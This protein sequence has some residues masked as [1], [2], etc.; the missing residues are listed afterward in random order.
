M[1]FESQSITIEQKGVLISLMHSK[2]MRASLAD[3]LAEVGTSIRVIKVE[4]VLKMLSDVIRFVL[5][6]IVHEEFEEYRLVWLVLDS[7]QHIYY[8]T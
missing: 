4:K 2:E 1:L 8:Q 3:I 7:S 6:L 5:T